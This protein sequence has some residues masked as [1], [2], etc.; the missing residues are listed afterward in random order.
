MVTEGNAKY[1]AVA[2]YPTFYN[3][4]GF[5]SLSINIWVSRDLTSGNEGFYLLNQLFHLQ[6]GDNIV[7][8]DKEALYSQYQDGIVPSKNPQ[9]ATAEYLWFPGLRRRR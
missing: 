4:S 8:I 3:L 1:Y 5:D 9:Y 6:A 7:T 2:V